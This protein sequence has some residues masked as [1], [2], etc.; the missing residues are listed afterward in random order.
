M[1]SSPTRQNLTPHT[2]PTHGNSH[3]ND[4]L[5][6]LRCQISTTDSM[7]PCHNPI[8][9]ISQASPRDSSSHLSPRHST[10]VRLQSIN[11]ASAQTAQCV[12][13]HPSRTCRPPPL[14]AYP[15]YHREPVRLGSQREL[16]RGRDLVGA[17]P[18]T[19]ISLCLTAAHTTREP[20]LC[21]VCISCSQP[22]GGRVDCGPRRVAV[23][24]WFICGVD[25]GGVGG[26]ICVVEV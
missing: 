5:I 4:T 25:V 21:T 8:Y 14:L 7:S 6:L 9:P 1:T 20:I 12:A 16:G 24:A 15:G 3:N 10:S 13:C 23:A 19:C 17:V 11:L 18:H 2:T 26:W 22:R